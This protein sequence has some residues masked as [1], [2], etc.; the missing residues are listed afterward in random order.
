MSPRALGLLGLCSIG[1][2]PRRSKHTPHDPQVRPPGLLHPDHSFP[3]PHL[4][5]HRQRWILG[6]RA[7]LHRQ[8]GQLDAAVQG[9]QEE[10][11]PVPD[12]LVGARAV[13]WLGG[14]GGWEGAKCN[15]I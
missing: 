5:E 7:D 13:V 9:V 11:L 1:Q 14:L 2:P 4:H 3:D 8:Q 6:T 10:H 15:V 12:P